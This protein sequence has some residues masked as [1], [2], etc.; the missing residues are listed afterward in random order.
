M[1]LRNVC[2]QLQNYIVLN[3]EYHSLKNSCVK[4]GELVHKYFNM[5]I[6]VLGHLEYNFVMVLKSG[7]S[8]DT[9]DDL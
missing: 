1:F 2:I 9:A 8:E 6:S 5:S 7:N 3:P 4:I